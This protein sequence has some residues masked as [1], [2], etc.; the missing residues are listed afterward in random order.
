[1]G[2]F[3]AFNRPFDPVSD[4]S[5]AGIGI[6]TLRDAI[7][8]SSADLA[9]AVAVVLIVALLA[10]PVLAL[11][12][13]TRVAA[14]HRGWALRAAAVLGVVWVALRLVGA[15]VA[16]SSAAALAVDQVQAV[17]TRPGGS[18]AARAP[19]RPRPLPHDPG[20]PAADRPARQGR[21]ARVR[22]ELRAGRG[23]GLVL[24]APHRRRARPGRRAAP[25]AAGFSSR[26]AFLTSPTFGGLSW[27]AHSTLQSGI[28]VDGQRRYD[29]LVQNDRLT[30]TR[31]FK[32]AGWRTVADVPANR[33]AWPQGASFYGY[34]AIYDRRNLGYRGPG[35][36][37]PPM[38]DQYAL[39]AL[40][41]LELAKRQRPPLFAEVDLISSHAPWTQD[42]PAH[43]LE[44]GRRRLDL[45]PHPRRGVHAG[46]A[47]RRRRARPRRLRALDRVLAAHA[48]LVRA[49]LRRRRHRARRPRRPPARDA[50]QRRGRRP[51]RADLG[52]R[53]RPEGDATGSPAGAGRTACCRARRR[54]SGR[55]P[56][57]ATASSPRS[58]RDE[59]GRPRALRP[60]PAARARGGVRPRRVRRAGELHDR[61]R[62]PGAGDAG[63]RRPRGRGAR[64]VLRRRRARALAHARA[65]LRLPRRRC[66]RERPGHRARGGGARAASRSRRS[67]PCPAGSFD[68]VLL[69]EAMLAFEDK[70][71]LVARGRRGAAA[72]RALRLHARGGA[73]AHAGQ[74]GRRCPTPTR[75][76]SPRSPSW[77]RPWSG[78][79]SSSP[80]R[81]TTADAHRA[82]A[83]A[84]TAAFAADAAAIAEQI[85]R[86]ALD[87]LLA[88]HR[89]WIEWLDAGRVRKLALVASRGL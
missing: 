88:A 8:S 55:W 56:R 41:R 71:A 67:R 25:R 74:S 28:R 16:S 53:P 51:R 44:R 60:G 66:Q 64:P 46:R 62:D 77:P 48:L 72:R 86:R 34:D 10:F 11:L 38:P 73:A 13:V 9:V 52:H 37:L 29:Q 84:L 63:R 18:R 27:L 49:A 80:C 17:R 26:S 68:V 43:P 81:R 22:R 33:R 75:S 30:L 23:P 78:P 5:Y 54:R 85:G 69:L 35:F 14:G 70:D 87:E 89:L 2:F 4:S 82:T 6:E 50:R 47:V 45:R 21:A 42:P 12:R 58:A 65:G 39:H 24:L 79:G 3:T 59:A 19:A 83:Q 40:Q 57:S 7:G 36:G 32:R 1:M 76:G 20:R 31:A 61:G 15:P